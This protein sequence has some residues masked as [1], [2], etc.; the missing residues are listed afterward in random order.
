MYPVQI[1]TPKR[2]V[3]SI[4]YEEA[5]SRTRQNAKAKPAGQLNVN[6]TYGYVVS[7]CV[8]KCVPPVA[9]ALRYGTS[10]KKFSFLLAKGRSLPHACQTTSIL[11]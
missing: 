10:T 7:I 4:S 3:I 1:R 8:C 5:R 6:R 9:I 11:G 2:A